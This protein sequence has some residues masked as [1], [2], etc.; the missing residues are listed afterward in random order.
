MPVLVGPVKVTSK[1]RLAE[2]VVA[3]PEMLTPVTT[4]E[5]REVRALLMRALAAAASA[6]LEPQRGVEVLPMAVVVYTAPS[7][8]LKRKASCA[9]EVKST[10]EA[11]V[12]REGEEAEP[13]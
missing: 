9:E 11:E 5:G 4:P 3:S 8:A 1:V 13:K 10:I 7:M 12:G 2:E 6:A